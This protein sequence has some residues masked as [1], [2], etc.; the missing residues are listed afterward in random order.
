MY[1]TSFLVILLLW[2]AAS[3]QEISYSRDIRPILSNRCFKCHGPDLKKAGLDLQSRDTA[4]KPRGKRGPAIVPGNS[5]ESRLLAR[6]LSKEQTERMPPR[7][8][9]LTAAQAGKLKAWIDQGAKYEEHWAFV[10][11]VRHPLPVVTDRSWPRN[12]I[13]FFVLARLEQEKLVPAPEADRAALLRRAS[14]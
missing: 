6:V 13:D 14:E 5:G 11:P 2:P 1:R 8:N 3:G 10:K 9:A 12:A 7:G 4:V